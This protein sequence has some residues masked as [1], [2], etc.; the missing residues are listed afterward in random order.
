M[1]IRRLP[2]REE[3]ACFLSGTIPPIPPVLERR[4]TP[5]GCPYDP[6]P[7]PKSSKN[8]GLI[9]DPHLNIFGVPKNAK[10]SIRVEFLGVSEGVLKMEPR[11]ELPKVRFCY[12]LLHLS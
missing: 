1:E 7:F 9:L 10:K 12:Y 11:P 6:Y 4:K 2:S 5:V 8:G 3:R